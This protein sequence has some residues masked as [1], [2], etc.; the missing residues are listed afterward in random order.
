M[1][2]EHK[3][4]VVPNE[5]GFGPSALTSYIVKDL[6]RSRQAGLHITIWNRSRY[7]YNR[8][9][10]QDAIRQR[11]LEVLPV[12]NIIELDKPPEQ[13]GM[14]SIPGTLDRIGD[15]RRASD[16]YP[17]GNPPSDF[18]LVLDFGVPAAARWAARKGIPSVS[19]IDHAWSKTLQMIFD[20][21]YQMYPEFR[22][23]LQQHRSSW[24]GLVEEVKRDEAF[25][26]RLFI[27]PPF[28]TPDVFRKHW[29]E[30]GVQF[31]DMGAVL[32]GR[33][34]QT[35][36][37]ARDTLGL[38]EAG[39]TIL[40]QGGDSPVWDTVLGRVTD[41]FIRAE[42]E[43]AL[44]QRKLNVVVNI[45][46]RMAG[47]PGIQELDDP[48]LRRVR[49]LGFIPGG[50]VQDILPAIDL[51][52]TRAGGG[53]V[54]DAVA[55]RTPFV[56]VREPAHSQVEEILK[57]CQHWGLTRAIEPEQ[58]QAFPMQTVLEQYERTSENRDRV[59]RMQAI[60][61]GGEQK[62]TGEVLAR[63]RQ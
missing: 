16:L 11:A 22:E 9:L 54:N 43:G 55:C 2:K 37:V 12:W 20:D 57:A 5:D 4:L 25:L 63:L 27:F 31:A 39:D 30:M 48:S 56:C 41:D 21:Q 50:T 62:I 61:H 17:P 60:A 52:V 40:I 35:A 33:R 34:D 1:S 15:Y 29:T 3:I 23:T 53:S 46:R 47:D 24:T 58:F 14:V 6:L 10:Y 38:T 8:N 59:S 42:R 32:G 28:I 13:N 45:P 19:V 18:D 26:Q 36:Q 44:G 7:D 49:K 51:L